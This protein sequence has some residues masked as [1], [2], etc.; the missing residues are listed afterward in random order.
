MSSPSPDI[1]GAICSSNA[2]FLSRWYWRELR[3]AGFTHS[4]RCSGNDYRLL[5]YLLPDAGLVWQLLDV[6]ASFFIITF[7]FALIF[8]VVPDVTVDW[9]DVWLGALNYGS[10]LCRR[11]D[12][13][14]LLSGP[15]WCGI[16]VSGPRGLCCYCWR[17]FTIR[18]RFYF[19]ERSSR[20]STR[21]NAGRTSGRFEASSR[22]RNKPG[23]VRVERS[24]NGTTSVR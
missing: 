15:Q 4:E 3:P 24:R 17:G 23:S 21:R 14:C 19:S 1:T 8:K 13:H 5:S 6:G 11:K 9:R 18:H 2:C 7:L 22:F 12:S 10:A 20:S 16:G